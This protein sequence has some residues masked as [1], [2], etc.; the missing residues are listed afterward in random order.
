METP[1]RS[2]LLQPLIPPIVFNPAS[3][4]KK[5]HFD[6]IIALVTIKQNLA[7]LLENSAWDRP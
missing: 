1:A 2:R 5:E 3:G 4:F 6:Q 7:A